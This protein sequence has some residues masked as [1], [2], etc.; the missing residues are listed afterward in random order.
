MSRIDAVIIL[1][2]LVAGSLSGQNCVPTY[3]G[4][5][6]D[7]CLANCTLSGYAPGNC[8]LCKSVT[9]TV[10][11]PDGY[12]SYANTLNGTG[13]YNEIFQ[14]C[15]EDLSFVYNPSPIQCWPTY[16]AATTSQY[17]FTQTE[18]NQS[19]AIVRDTC[20]LLPTI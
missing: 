5:E 15:D 11:F 14:G 10:V 12:N 20:G 6:T 18:T 13:A 7:D 19:V 4:I 1:A 8:P 3:S 9:Y 16:Y 17:S 2:T